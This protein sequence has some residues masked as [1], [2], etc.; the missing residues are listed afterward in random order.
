MNLNE[1]LEAWYDAKKKITQLT[2]DIEK[3]RNL[4][5]YEMTKHGSNKVENKSFIATKRK[6]K[7]SYVSKDNMPVDLWKKYSINIEYDCLSIKRKK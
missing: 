2:K 7:K 5:L 4:V 3:Y 6:G 1:T